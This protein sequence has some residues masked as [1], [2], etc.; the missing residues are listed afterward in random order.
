[1]RFTSS[2]VY[3]ITVDGVAYGGIDPSGDDPVQQP[4][5]SE[6]FHNYLSNGRDALLWGGE[7]YLI[8]SPIN[9]KSHL[10]RIVDRIRDGSLGA[11]EIVIKRVDGG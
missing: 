10:G 7:P 4:G 11:R 8:E 2:F 6:S 5:F 1:M 3:T 9:L